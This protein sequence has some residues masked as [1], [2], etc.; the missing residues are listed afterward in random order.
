MIDKIMGSAKQPRK[1]L[2]KIIKTAGHQL[3]TLVN[4]A[5]QEA[6]IRKITVQSQPWANSSLDPILKIPITKHGWW[7]GSSGS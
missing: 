1:I 6:E 2:L 5:T 3:L 7:D 4:L